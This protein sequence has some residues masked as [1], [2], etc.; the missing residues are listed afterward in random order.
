MVTI[1]SKKGKCQFEYCERGY[2]TGGTKHFNSYVYV[3]DDGAPLLPGTWISDI[4]KKYKLLRGMQ[5]ST[6]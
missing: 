6:F 1:R 3:G 2:K 4:G 5:N